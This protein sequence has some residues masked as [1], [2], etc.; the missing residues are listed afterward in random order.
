M[1]DKILK[2]NIKYHSCTVNRL[3][4]KVLQ[5]SLVI[6]PVSLSFLVICHFSRMRKLIFG[7][8]IVISYY[9]TDGCYISRCTEQT[10]AIIAVGPGEKLTSI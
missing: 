8:F 2:E 10:M 1:P 4:F 6:Y 7:L 9:V 3:D 5:A